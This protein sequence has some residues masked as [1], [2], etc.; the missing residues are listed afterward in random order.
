VA[1]GSQT[2][3]RKPLG[4]RLQGQLCLGILLCRCLPKPP[5]TDL[6][7]DRLSVAVPIAQAKV[8]LGSSVPLVCGFSNLLA[9]FYAVLRNQMASFVGHSQ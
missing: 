6:L 7:I 4:D 5:R 3:S 8:V 9:G 1:A 2:L